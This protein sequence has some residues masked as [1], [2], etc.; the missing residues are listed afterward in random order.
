FSA[1]RSVGPVIGGTVG[2]I[3]VALVVVIVL[4]VI[5]RRKYACDCACSFKLAKKEDLCENTNVEKKIET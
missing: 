1:D 4:V 2:G 5:I 3:A